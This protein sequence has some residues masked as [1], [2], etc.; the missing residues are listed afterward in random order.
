MQASRPFTSTSL[1]CRGDDRRAG[2][3]TT[4]AV[5]KPTKLGDGHASRVAK[6]RSTVTPSMPGNIMRHFVKTMSSEGDVS[7]SPESPYIAHRQVIRDY[8]NQ[9]MPLPMVQ[10]RQ[11]RGLRRSSFVDNS[12]NNVGSDRVGNATRGQTNHHPRQQLPR[13]EADG[14]VASRGKSTT[15]ERSRFLVDSRSQRHGVIAASVYKDLCS[16]TIGW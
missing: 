6:Q 10:Q 14:C 11:P 9:T 15:Y 7:S 5:A 4:A 13:Y 12:D 3:T 2:A 8:L 1:N 16:G